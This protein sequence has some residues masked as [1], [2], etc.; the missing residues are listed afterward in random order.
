MTTLRPAPPD[1]SRPMPKPTKVGRVLF[2]LIKAIFGR[3][4][5]K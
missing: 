3:K 4:G 1:L 5:P 2:G